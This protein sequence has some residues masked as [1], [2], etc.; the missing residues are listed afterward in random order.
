MESY[1]QIQTQI[2][3]LQKQADAM[4]K[5]EVAAAIK[6]IKRLVSL[7]NLEAADLGMAA[8]GLSK[9]AA[10]A[11]GAQLAKAR[12]AKAKL[13][14]PA[15]KMVKKS[16]DKRASVAPKYRDSDDSALTWTGRGKPPR[17]LSS[18]IAAGASKESF[19]I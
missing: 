7:Y 16:G 4:R 5:Q 12:S 18:K 17:W 19:L 1:E 8:G 9:K 3:D 14:K 6:E 2:A 10:S 13:A 11:K 15:K